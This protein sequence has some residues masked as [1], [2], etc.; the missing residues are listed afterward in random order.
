MNKVTTHPSRRQWAAVLSILVLAVVCLAGPAA[1]LMASHDGQCA[2][3]EC[4]VAFHCPDGSAALVSAP[5]PAR[6]E[7]PVAQ[8]PV[9]HHL[10]PAEGVPIMSES[11]TLAL[12]TRRF[13]PL[14][15]RSPPSL[16]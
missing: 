6:V 10:T 7:L 2:S 12:A 8:L 3:P 4:Q 11:A 1:A 5:A 9:V 14:A 16:L 15:P 13:G